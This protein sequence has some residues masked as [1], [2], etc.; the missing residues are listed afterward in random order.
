MHKEFEHYL[1]IYLSNRNRAVRSSHRPM[2][3]FM[4]LEKED[5]GLSSTKNVF[6]GHAAGIQSEAE[7]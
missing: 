6:C 5:M 1:Y 7:G 2:F 4:I 3:I